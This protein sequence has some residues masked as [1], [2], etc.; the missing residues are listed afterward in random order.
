[1]VV[2]KKMADDGERAKP[3]DA[4]RTDLPSTKTELGTPI[5]K[6]LGYTKKQ[7]AD[8][9][10]SQLPNGT[11]KLAQLGYFAAAPQRL[12]ALQASQR[13]TARTLGV[14]Q[15]TVSRDLVETNVSPET[16]TP[17]QEDS[18]PE[19]NVSPEREWFADTTDPAELSQ[20]RARRDKAAR[21]ADVA[22]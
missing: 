15:M 21:D 4:K 20:K 12:E 19:T 18:P 16:G 8:A 5:L 7:S 6:D 9:R 2:L 3:K 17:V 11:V 22:P 13:A 10:K 1:L 14:T